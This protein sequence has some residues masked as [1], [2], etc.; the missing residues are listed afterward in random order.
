[1]SDN[2][3]TITNR[4]MA[5]VHRR[6]RVLKQLELAWAMVPTLRLGEVLAGA[7]WLE[8]RDRDPG[9]VDDQDLVDAAIQYAVESGHIG[10]RLEGVV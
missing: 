9:A 10:A 2:V 7:A 3:E 1:M 5:D 4:H 8:S 6:A